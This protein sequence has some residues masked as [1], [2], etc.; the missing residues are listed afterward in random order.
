MFLYKDNRL[1]LK[2]GDKILPLEEI[3]QK[4]KTPFYLYD[5]QGIRE[6][7]RFFMSSTENKLKVFFAM[8]AN[9]N[10]FL[11]KAFREEGAGLDVVSL[12]EA[13]L[14][15]D[16]GF[17][18]RKIVFSGVGKSLE[19]LE[20]AVENHFFQINVESFEE[21]K[22]LSLICEKKK[23]TAQIG[24]R[25]NPNVDF[26]SHPY[27]KTGLSGHKFGLEEEELP[28]L[29]N[30]IKQN[31]WLQL[32]GLSMH[33]GSQICDTEPLL[34]AIDSL[35]TLYEQ[36]KQ[37]HFPLKVLDIGG[38]LGINYETFNLEEDKQRL[39]DFN[40]GLNSVFKSF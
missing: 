32:Q 35:R 8:K 31:K 20:M 36:I 40:K 34:K 14:A 30:F 19:E 11:L 33:L 38:G 24:L 37:Q 16:L 6:W 25:I 28:P 5:I 22:R 10:P 13:R 23:K 7:Y 2:Q 21:L 18:P 1:V 9:F 29:L 15:Q 3:C 17:T 26:E 12:G 4:E 27:I 39:K